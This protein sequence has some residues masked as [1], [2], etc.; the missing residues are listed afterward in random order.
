VTYWFGATGG[1]T[2]LADREL[3]SKIIA[4]II[5]ETLWDLRIP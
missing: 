1:G 5:V 2:V 4:L 3:A